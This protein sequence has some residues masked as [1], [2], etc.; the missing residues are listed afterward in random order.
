M[1]LLPPPMILMVVC[2]ERTQ[3]LRPIPQRNYRLV[4]LP[5]LT[6]TVL[7]LREMTL[8]STRSGKMKREIETEDFLPLREER[9]N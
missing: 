5:T 2:H 4:I 9:P 1:A 7:S 8:N 6:C 3:P